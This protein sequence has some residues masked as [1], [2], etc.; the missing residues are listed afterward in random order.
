[1]VSA[2]ADRIRPGDWDRFPSRIRIGTSRILDLLD[3]HGVKATF[4]VL[5]WVAQRHPELVREIDARGH[6]IGCHSHEHRLVYEMSPEDF[7]KDTRRVLKILQDCIGKK[8]HGYRAPSYSI[9]PRSG[10]A[11]EILAEEGF[12]YDSSV[13]PIRHDRYGYPGF[14][15]TVVIQ[16]LG[17]RRIVEV[18]LSTLRLLGT[19]I[20]FGGGGYL[21]LYPI[22]FTEWAKRHIN[23]QERIPMIL[24]VHPWELDPNQPRLSGTAFSVFRHY[25]NLGGTVRKISRLLGNSGF[26]GMGEYLRETGFLAN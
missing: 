7:R 25:V 10:W 1:M 20:P 13:F 12:A 14:S 11:F 16:Q 6:E 2:F 8:I 22:W 5:G 4:F 15:R 9:T 23:D 26:Q 17:E 21:R 3:E 24:Y 18:P 19:S